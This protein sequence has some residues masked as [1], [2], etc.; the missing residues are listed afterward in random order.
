MVDGMIHKYQNIVVWF[1]YQVLLQNATFCLVP[2]GRRLGSFRFLE[3][4]QAGCVPVLLSNGWELPFSD[5][6]DWSK[7]AVTADERLLL[8]VPDMIRSLP[9]TRVHAF[10]QQT[11]VLW[12]NYFSSVDKIVDTTFEI[13]R[14]RVR[15]PLHRSFFV[16]NSHPGGLPTL[17][18]FS[19]VLRDFPFHLARLGQQPHAK[20]TAVIY[21][22]MAAANPLLR[23]VR[24]VAKS[25]NAARIVVIWN[26]E[27]VSAS[28]MKWP[29]S[30]IPI[31]VI[32][33]QHKTISSRFFPHPLIQTDAVLS[34]DEDVLLTTEEMDFAFSVWRSFPDRIVGYPGRSHFWDDAR[35]RWGYT[36]KWTNDYSMVL[37]GA[38]FYHRYYHFLYT[39]HVPSAA[40]RVVDSTQNCEDILMNFLVSH[41]TRL[42]PVKVT[43][44]KHYKENAPA[45][46]WNDPDHFVTRRSCVDAFAT[47]FGYMPLV[48][49]STRLDPVLFKDPVSNLRKKYRKMEVVGGG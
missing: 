9:A 7:A 12:D 39:H 11:Q 20:F 43:Q 27:G 18:E 10:R 25:E 32:Q 6:L 47:V 29:S 3:A 49:S 24:A 19:D 4:I 14:E 31:N 21:V 1:D 13:I 22:A 35:G 15:V 26:S 42:P 36:S 8:Q 17:P 40:H 45:S 5:V 38:A 37:T 30:P 28:S 48:R 16:W 34:L 46:L 44:R 2:R 33:A 41:V 23:L